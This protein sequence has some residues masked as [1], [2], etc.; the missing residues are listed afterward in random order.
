MA[1]CSLNYLRYGEFCIAKFGN[2]HLTFYR[3]FVQEH[4]ISPAR[5]LD[6]NWF[7]L[8]RTVK[9]WKLAPTVSSSP[10][11]EMLYG[12]SRKLIPNYCWFLFSALCLVFASLT[13]PIDLRVPLLTAIALVSLL[14]TLFGSVQ[15]EFRYPFDPIFT[16]FTVHASHCLLTSLRK[17][18]MA[19][20]SERISTLLRRLYAGLRRFKLAR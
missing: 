11:A 8:Q 15:W 3:L 9:E 12:I 14:V 4:V 18:R 19:L 7:G 16:A 6:E 13:G 2:A 17:S 5:R 20:L 10:T 1:F